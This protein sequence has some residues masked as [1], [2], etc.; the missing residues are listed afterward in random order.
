M[1]AGPFPHNHRQ[2]SARPDRT[3]LPEPD[4]EMTRPL[5]LEENHL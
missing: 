5:S 3:L 4:P 1:R 2:E